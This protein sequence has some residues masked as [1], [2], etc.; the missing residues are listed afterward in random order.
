MIKKWLSRGLIFLMIVICGYF[1]YLS[2]KTETVPIEKTD[3]SKADLPQG[4]RGRDVRHAA[5]DAEGN[6]IQSGTSS[7][8]TLIGE[9]QLE[10]EGG[11]EL[12][13]TENG[14]R[15]HIKA[16]RY[17]NNKDKSQVLEAA[18]GSVVILA[19]SDGLRLETPGPVV[20][21]PDGTYTSDAEV[22]FFLGE[23]RGTCKGL[24]YQPYAFVELQNAV[25]FDVSRGDQ[26]AVSIEAEHLKLDQSKARGII[27]RGVVD[28]VDE[29]GN[30]AKL[31]SETIEFS[32]RTRKNH[33]IIMEQATVIGEPGRF[34]WNQGALQSPRLDIRFDEN[35]R[36]LRDI[37]TGAQ[38]R[39]DMAAEDGYRMNADTGALTLTLDGSLPSK[40]TS[41]DP[42]TLNAQRDTPATLHLVGE[43]GLETQFE[44]GRAV[45]TFIT[46]NP[47]FTYGGQAGKAGEL[48]I[49]HR[50]R[51][52]I[53]SSGSELLDKDEDISIYGDRILLT[54]WDQEEREI[55]AFRFV[56]ITYRL[57][58]PT[59]TRCWGDQL[60][61]KLPSHTFKITGNPAK[62]QHEE[63]TI[64]APEIN[65]R[66][67]DEDLFEL[68]TDDRVSLNLQTEEGLFQLEAK[69]MKLSQGTGLLVFQNV[70]E[71]VLPGRGKLSCDLMEV[72]V[73]KE[74]DQ[75]VVER[76]T[77]TGDVLFQGSVTDKEGKASPVSGQSET[78]IYTRAED[79]LQFLGNNKDVVFNH[80]SG[81][82]VGP[83][84]TYNLKDATMRS[85]PGTTRINSKI[86]ENS[87][88]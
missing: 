79:T 75:Q 12:E 46:G 30:L 31:Q 60:E 37:R 39:F 62:L 51:N 55:F 3:P 59:P 61:L 69:T 58:E 11:L 85:G 34:Q 67:I 4:L 27:Q 43:K 24:R 20:A 77:A 21:H 19:E 84:L 17:R 71:A 56:T 9:D 47:T 18:K 41:D 33:N 65:L 1:V 6:L 5:F 66:K 54:N 35:G 87:Q 10:L 16:D 26:G 23:S 22:A 42:L 50:E 15:Y 2:T 78:M 57:S 76:L 14:R 32:F 7:Q 13:A 45:N 40:L 73:K 68:E 52:I 8:V 25:K 72:E 70:T 28:C 86:V 29:A 53:F 82:F 83:E 44:A 80:P 81:E 88:N 49:S 63:H 36:L 48:R 74:N 38:A 64:K